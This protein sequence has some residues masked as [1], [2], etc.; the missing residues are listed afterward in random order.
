MPID[1]VCVH[2]SAIVG[3]CALLMHHLHEIQTRSRFRVKVDTEEGSGEGGCNMEITPRQGKLLQFK[4]GGGL[5][6]PPCLKYDDAVMAWRGWR[7]IVYRHSAFCSICFICSFLHS[8]L[9]N[10]NL[11]LHYISPF[12]IFI[13]LS[14]MLFD[15]HVG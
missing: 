9:I 11:T 14:A 13:I 12:D 15:Y 10:F 2:V 4:P 1:V 8:V 7:S 3:L 6:R 5:G